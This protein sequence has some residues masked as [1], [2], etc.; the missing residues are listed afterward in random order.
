MVAGLRIKAHLS[1]RTLGGVSHLCLGVIACVT[2][3]V[4]LRQHTCGDSGAGVAELR[5]VRLVS[6]AVDRKI[7]VGVTA[8]LAVDLADGVLKYDL[9]ILTR[10]KMK[11]YVS[12]V[13]GQRLDQRL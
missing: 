5:D 8:G 11:F 9:L 7:G 10:H 6:Q 13:K 4:T 12:K 2:E 3:Q 1:S